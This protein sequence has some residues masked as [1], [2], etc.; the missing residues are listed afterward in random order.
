MKKT[1]TLLL[2]AVMLTIAISPLTVKSVQAEKADMIT[3]AEKQI[4]AFADSIDK[5]NAD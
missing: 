3:T 2:A 4:R 1:L 5:A